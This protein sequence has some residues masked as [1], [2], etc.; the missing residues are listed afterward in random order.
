MQSFFPALAA[1]LI[2]TYHDGSIPSTG[3][4]RALLAKSSADLG[5]LGASQRNISC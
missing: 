3:R 5:L 4:C 1:A 2:T